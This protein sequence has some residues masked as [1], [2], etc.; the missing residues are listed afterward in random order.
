MQKQSSSETG[1]NVLR[2]SLPVDVGPRSQRQRIVAAMLDSCAEKT[3]AATTISD[4]VGRASISRTTFYK[5]FPDK[6]ACFG[7]TLEFALD[8]LRAVA[9]AS[10]SRADS[11]AEAVRKTSAAILETL[12]ARPELAQLL[13]AEAVAVDPA[14]PHRYGQLLVPALEGLWREDGAPVRHTDPGL[15]A[16]RAHLLIFSEIAGGRADRLPQLHP[17][18]VYLA[19]VPFAGHE[20]AVRQARLASEDVCADPVA[21]P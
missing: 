15:V 9:A 12:A 8:E 19:L 2:P 10:V 3:Y 20:E 17:E 1:R 11:P 4:I 5:H 13:A 6:R 21:Q 7:A 16:G 14:S 18:M